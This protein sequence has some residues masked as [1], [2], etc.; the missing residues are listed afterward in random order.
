MFSLCS[1]FQCEASTE[2]DLPS[3]R[4]AAG[5]HFLVHQEDPRGTFPKCLSH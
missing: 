3:A 2:S 4:Q 5:D 1:A